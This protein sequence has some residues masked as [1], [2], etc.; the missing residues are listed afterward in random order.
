LRT[1]SAHDGALEILPEAQLLVLAQR[2]RVLHVQSRREKD[3]G[4]RLVVTPT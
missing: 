1:E 3:A 4:Q 2:R